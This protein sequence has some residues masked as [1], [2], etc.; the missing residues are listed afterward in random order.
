MPIMVDIQRVT[1]FGGE[2]G[3]GL[4][5]TQKLALFADEMLVVPEGHVAAE[6]IELPAGPQ[7]EVREK[8][9]LPTPRSVPVHPQLAEQLSD[10]E[11]RGLITGRTWVV[12][13]LE[14]RGVN[15]R[16]FR[17]ANEEHVLCT[18]VDTKDLC[19]VWFMSLVQTEHIKV[20]I[21]SGATVSFFAPRMREYLQPL[22]EKRELEASVLAQ[23]RSEHP[24]ETRAKVLERLYADPRFR[25]QV[26]AGAPYEEVLEYARQA[27]GRKEGS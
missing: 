12:S 9:P 15:E 10:D 17:I 19:D 7:S 2:R 18:V 11:L 8:L 5:K 23:I 13:D 25:S 1:V 26:D 16:I 3:E 4:Q 27:A 6:T 20:G 24:R 21:S 14:N 22:V